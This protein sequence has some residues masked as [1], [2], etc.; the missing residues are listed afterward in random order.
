MSFSDA[1]IDAIITGL[2]L[3]VLV[4]VTALIL[5]CIPKRIMNKVWVKLHMDNDEPYRDDSY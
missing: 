3:S 5:Q 2:I 1:A 4:G